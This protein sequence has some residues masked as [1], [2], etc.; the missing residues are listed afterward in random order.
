MILKQQSTEIEIILDWKCSVKIEL[1]SNYVTKQS[2]I[3]EYIY[4]R[5]FKFR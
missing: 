1:L 5:D 3:Q 4:T 2:F